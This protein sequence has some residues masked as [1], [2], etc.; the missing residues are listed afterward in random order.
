MP[1]KAAGVAPTPSQEKF[2]DPSGEGSDEALVL[3]E[4]A[5]TTNSTTRGCTI[6]H[7]QLIIFYGCTGTGTGIV[8]ILFSFTIQFFNYK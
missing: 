3:K 4:A 7:F 5:E 2:L 8:D 6:P 1:F